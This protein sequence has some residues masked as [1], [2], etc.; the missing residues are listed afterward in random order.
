MPRVVPSQVVDLI[1]QVFPWAKD[2]KSDPNKPI[3]I[4]A[5]HIGVLSAIDGM[6]QAVPDDLIT[7][8]PHDSSKYN[9]AIWTLRA[10]LERWR[11]H[12]PNSTLDKVRGVD[13][14]NPVAVLRN[15]LAKCPDEPAG[16]ATKGFEFINDAVLRQSLLNDL[17]A[18]S[19]ALG[20]GEWKAATVLG[21]SF[22]EALLLW[23]ATD[24]SGKKQAEFQ[25]GIQAAVARELKK[26]PP[27]KL[28]DWTL[29]QLIEVCVDCS[30][31]S[32]QTATQA[33]LSKAFRNLIHPG[34]A[35]RLAA[36]CNIGTAMAARAAIEFVSQD[37]AKKVI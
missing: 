9:A 36:E 10:Q 31:I 4:Y 15:C 22:L 30:L 2:Q 25:A 19:R 20:N 34:R 35:I 5:D 11:V 23:A 17:A 14:R 3:V 18:V 12:G 16:A 37:L 33:R 13:D 26:T 27:T 21:G 8:Q 1:D 29:Y 6:T 7:L 28:E 24:F 32:P